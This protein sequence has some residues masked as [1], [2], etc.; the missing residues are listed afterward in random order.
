LDIKSFLGS[1]GEPQR[2]TPSDVNRIIKDEV[3]AQRIA[4]KTTSIEV[5]TTVKINDGPFIEFIGEVREL[6][7]EKN[8]A[9]VLVKIFERES[10]VDLSLN[11]IEKYDRITS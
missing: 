10:I 9:K 8:K 5:G 2:M 1:K 4:E 11:Q 7:L 3:L 6:N